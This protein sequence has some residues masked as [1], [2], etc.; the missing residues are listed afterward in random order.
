M[1]GEMVS[2]RWARSS[3]NGGR[4]HSGIAGGSTSEPAAA[5]R[6]RGGSGENIMVSRQSSVLI[7]Q[8]SAEVGCGLVLIAP[9][10][11]AIATMEEFDVHPP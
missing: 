7:R 2:E 4:L 9:S 1:A 6:Y 3:R 10:A 5:L 11:A 8:S